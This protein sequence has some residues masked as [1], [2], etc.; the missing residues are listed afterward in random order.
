MRNSTKF[1]FLFIAVF[2]VISVIYFAPLVFEN[3]VISQHDI[4]MWKGGAQ[5]II[6]FKESNGE[7]PLWTNSMFSGM[8]SYLVGIHYDGNLLYTLRKA[9]FVVPSAVFI[10]FLLWYL[11]F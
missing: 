8:P 3:K 4:N 7:E 1:S 6:E 2:F 10:L 9:L 11:G 5:E